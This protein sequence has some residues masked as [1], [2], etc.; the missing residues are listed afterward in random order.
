MAS[1]AASTLI[2]VMVSSKLF[3]LPTYLPLLT[4]MATSASVWLTTMKPP[5][6]SQTFCRVARWIS[7]VRLKWSKIEA[8]REYSFTRD[9]SVGMKRSTKFT[10]AAYSASSSTQIFWKLSSSLSRRSFSTRS[11]SS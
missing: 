9:R 1:L 6:G 4:S 2:L 5:E 8:S 10:M 7:G 3:P 11:S